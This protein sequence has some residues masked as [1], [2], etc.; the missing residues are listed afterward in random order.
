M[1]QQTDE[2]IAAG[3]QKGDTEIFGQLVERYEPKMTRYAHKFLFAHADAQDL[4]QEVFIKAFVHI[5]S[6]DAKRKFSSWLYRIAHNEFINALKRKEKGP[7]Y[8]FDPDTFWPHPLS[9]ETADRDI[10]EKELK[11]MMSLSLNKLQPKYR[12]P[13]V[14]YYYEEMDYKEIAEVL[15]IPIATVGV[16]RQRAKNKLKKIVEKINEPGGKSRT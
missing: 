4:V 11:E 12:E 10:N 14:L 13:L 8:F 3:V 2:E 5:K 16:T 1:P 15:K 6:F 9:K 7:L